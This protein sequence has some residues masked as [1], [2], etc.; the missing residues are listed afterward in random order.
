MSRKKWIAIAV[1]VILI[2]GIGAYVLLALP[3]HL[4]AV[5]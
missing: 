3:W 1:A 2:V 5:S 4:T